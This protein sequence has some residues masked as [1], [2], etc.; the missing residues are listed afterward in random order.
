[1]TEYL[2]RLQKIQLSIFGE[3]TVYLMIFKHENFLF[4]DISISFDIQN[5]EGDFEN[6]EIYNW[7][8]KAKAKREFDKI[9]ARL[10][11]LGHNV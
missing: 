1:M 5:D 10:R 6:H 11:E 8:T 4:D 7:Q 3:R 9:R 2:K